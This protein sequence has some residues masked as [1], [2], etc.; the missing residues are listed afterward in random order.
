MTGEVAVPS[1]NSKDLDQMKART[2]LVHSWEIYKKLWKK[3]LFLTLL[4]YISLLPLGVIAAIFVFFGFL[5]SS[6]HNY[7][8]II[9]LAAVGII[10]AAV[11]LSITFSIGTVAMMYLISEW[12]NSLS[13][14]ESLKK[15]W[16]IIWAYWWLGFLQSL[17]IL[18]GYFLFIAPGIIFSVWFSVGMY[19][20]IV[21]GVTGMNALIKSREYVRGYWWGVLG[22]FLFFSLIISLVTYIPSI[23]LH[24]LKQEGLGSIIQF[25][26]SLAAAPFTLI[27]TYLLYKG[28]KNLHP[29]ISHNSNSKFFYIVIA[30]LGF[31]VL[32]IMFYFA[33]VFGRTF[34][35]E[36]L[37]NNTNLPP[38]NQNQLP[39]F[40]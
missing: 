25:V 1:L 29:T 10:L 21:E 37:K 27:Y 28:L 34:I 14:R 24:F 5:L 36:L 30:I 19:V 7:T 3:L 35:Q 20:L 33:I 18:G 15:G 38:F 40:T 11:Y 9:L 23:L 26:L 6:S 17:L 13:I 39:N 2:I 16:N 8:G 22:R 31:I 4:P 32:C 12:E